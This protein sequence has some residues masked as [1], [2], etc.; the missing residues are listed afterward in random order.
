[1]Y[2]LTLKSSNVKTGDIPVSTS[3]KNNCPYDCPLFDNGCYGDNHGLNFHW[4]KVTNNLRGSNW[5]Q[6][7][8]QVKSIPNGTIWRHNQVGDLE[9]L[10]NND[11][12]I[13][14]VKLGELV[15]A[16]LGKKG[17]TYTH[18]TENP[19]NHEWIK[20][21]NNW[22]FT[23]NLSANNLDHADY[24]MGL[25]IAPV[26]TIL[27]VDSLKKITTKKG[28]T[29][30]VCPQTYIDDLTCKDCKLCQISDR[31]TIV[32]FPSHGSGKN[33]VNKVFEI[34]RV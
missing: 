30:I 29:V 7:I 28:N 21:S 4:R 12:L 8:D 27:P 23:I 24:L 9:G 25:N 26:V 33:K 18:K 2:H 5:S 31:S 6:F 34:K 13:D 15:E 14:P 17:F 32:G 19:I 22:G 20:H 10:K 3:P 16:N 1:M 11:N